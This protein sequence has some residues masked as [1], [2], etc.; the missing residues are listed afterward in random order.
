MNLQP[1]YS[2]Q[3]GGSLPVDAP[4]YVR[5]EA[6]N[7]LYQ[8]LITGQFCY[9]LN[10]RQMG[11]SSLRVQTMR[12]LQE[13]G[14]ACGAIDLTAI[15]S[16]DI[17]AEQ[18]Y[19][20]ILYSLASGFELL[21]KFD[22]LNWWHDRSFL[23]PIQRLSQFI[24]EV[25]LVEVTSNISIFIDEIDSI[26]S[27]NFNADDFFGLIRA[28][29]NKRSD[30]KKYQR[31]SFALLGV[32]TPSDL[33]RNRNVSTPFNIGQAVEL[34]GFKLEEAMPLA[35]GFEGVFPEAIAVVK[36]ILDWTGGQPFLTQKVC[37]LVWQLAKEKGQF[38]G[39][40]GD[41]VA[42]VVRSRII[43]NWEGKDEP[44]HL[45]TIG[46]R[47]LYSCHHK[48]ELL[49]SYRQIL[50]DGEIRV[51]NKPEQ[52]ELRLTGLVV[53]RDGKLK[54]YNRIYAA[55]F[56]LSWIE[57]ELG[58]MGWLPEVEEKEETKTISSPYSQE[59]IGAIE[60]MAKEA[61]KQFESNQIEA[62][63]LAIQAGQRLKA[64]VEDNLSESEYPTVVPISV[65][66]RI[67]DN[68]RE[69]N[70]FRGHQGAVNSVSFSSDGKYF[71]TG[72]FDGT[73]RLW[74]SAGVQMK[75]WKSHRGSV[76]SVNFSPD[77]K[78]I[79]T[80]GLDG[81]A[82]LWD[83]SGQE[84]VQFLGHHGSV[85]KAS[86]SPEGK[87]FATIDEESTVIVW[88]LSG[89]QI[90][91]WNTHQGR[92]RSISWSM[93]GRLIAT[94]GEDSTICLWDV[95]G[96][97]INQW[98]HSRGG[99]VGD[100]S[101][102]PDSQQIAAASGVAKL[103]DLS[104]EQLAQFDGQSL[105]GNVAFCPNG[106]C[107]ATGES[108]GSI[109]LWNLSGMQLALLSAHHGEC[110]A[111]GKSDRNVELWNMSQV[112]LALLSAHQGGIKS[113]SFSSNGQYLVSASIDG[114]SRFWDLSANNRNV[115]KLDE[116]LDRGC[117]WL[118]DYL[119][120]R[121]EALA[122]LEVCR[123][124][125]ER[126]KADK[127][128]EAIA[129]ETAPTLPR[130]AKH[131]QQR[132]I[133]TTSSNPKDSFFGELS[134]NHKL[135]RIYCGDITHLVVDAIVSSDDTRL[136][137]SGG[138]ARRIRAVGGDE[139]YAQVQKIAPIGLGQV[140][141]T[142][143][144]NL[145]AKKV[146]HPAVIDWSKKPLSS[147]QVIKQVVRICM[148]GARQN[149]LE[150][151]AFTVM[152]TGAGVLRPEVVWEAMLSQLKVELST[153]NQTVKEVAIAIYGIA[154]KILKIETLL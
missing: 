140:A 60:Q 122:R 96:K 75:C 131:P 54:V 57:R 151:I 119:T 48:R 129:R 112:Q 84:L 38:T 14:V 127:R 27:L 146:F 134:I 7:Q 148:I 12:R 123:R 79:V 132:L 98:L 80:T 116:L 138:V 28:C 11:K 66:Q 147:S 94:G 52:T 111:T 64:L 143:G 6:D 2:Y 56:N 99:W 29:Y 23:S 69:R 67:L 126:K 97:Q 135:I 88:D 102:S 8:G 108:D 117:D 26:L 59:E 100:L 83:S 105:V 72:G 71:I 25:L 10:S 24:E 68:I 34:Q 58:D 81:T 95:S 33:M 62:L 76:W 43:E 103:W 74:H 41:W 13:A 16:Q 51:N 73:T 141:V 87:Y 49:L 90:A 5:R 21:D 130:E 45:K 142:D 40:I 30:S 44:E 82:R 154:A 4:T 17:T 133:T 46:D 1:N 115:E 104:G 3:V 42:E 136:R 37:E 47:L 77:G 125:F 92:G 114:T 150:S 61:S 19:G 106:E 55:V 113:L 20:G 153:K 86:W 101:F 78:R 137:M 22:L 144:G 107:I 124:R 145:L 121:P 31:L 85:W 36:E 109:Q 15:G 35:K 152:A 128:E 18:W 70:R 63:I 9:V 118:Q 65:L 50:R 91:R 39:N 110:I 32:A 89:Q 93:D 139:I 149:N 53:K 120:T